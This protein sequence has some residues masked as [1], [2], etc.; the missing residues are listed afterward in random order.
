MS[1]QEAS[2]RTGLSTETLRYYEREQLLPAV[3]R[4]AGGHRRYSNEDLQR[5]SFLIRL[6]DTGMPIAV[7]RQFAALR[8]LGEPGRP[9]RLRLLLQHRASVRRRTEALQSNL[10]AIDLK[11][12]RHQ[13]ILREQGALE[14]IQPDVQPDQQPWSLRALHHVQLAMPRG[15]EDKARSFFRDALGMT[16]LQKPPVLA[17]RGGCWF[18]SPGL[19]LHL[20]VEEP[21]APARKAHPG[22]LVDNLP[23]LAA[24]LEA[25]GHPVSWDDNFPGYHRFY[26]TDPF[27][28][29]L[30]F[31]EP[32]NSSAATVTP[33]S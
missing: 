10:R 30:E 9:G 24:T 4:S 19:E 23:G 1:A 12:H 7:M 11:I 13:R 20:G 16:E 31:I 22:L 6:R 28:N 5:L 2:A 14:M 8:L 18:R 21:F 32:D 17:A 29:R 26:A 33:A 27:G 15:Q 3:A 25:A